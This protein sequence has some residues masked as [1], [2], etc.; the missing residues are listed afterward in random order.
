MIAGLS[1]KD[2]LT[3]PVSV[4]V[5]PLISLMRDQCLQMNRVG[6]RSC[7]LGSGQKDPSIEARAMRG[8]F[9][10]VYVCPETIDR[11]AGGLHQLHRKCGISVLAVDEAHW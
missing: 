8:D 6:V 3:R 2:N 5:S 7:L 4:I 9:T 10:L 11:I 1:V